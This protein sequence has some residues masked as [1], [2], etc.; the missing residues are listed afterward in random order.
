MAR[1]DLVLARESLAGARASRTG[2]LR[3][4]PAVDGLERVRRLRS[5]ERG[6]WEWP[7]QLISSRVSVESRF[8]RD[9]R[10]RREETANLANQSRVR[11][12]AGR[13]VWEV[14]PQPGPNRRRSLS[15]LEGEHVG[16]GEFRS[17]PTASERNPTGRVHVLNVRAERNLIDP[18]RLAPASSSATGPSAE[19]RCR[20]GAQ[21][22]VRVVGSH[23]GC[24]AGGPFAGS[25]F[26]AQAPTRTFSLA[27]GS[28]TLTCCATNATMVE[29]FSHR[30]TP[31]TVRRQGCVPEPVRPGEWRSCPC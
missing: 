19:G 13:E 12:K 2:R 26:Q 18:R 5:K 30:T 27:N 24:L 8:L 14:V 1:F 9:T 4:S 25:G 20:F 29:T 28:T 15:L 11:L 31:K 17:A 6:R 10:G 3:A 22:I 23:A 16:D 21:F 7:I